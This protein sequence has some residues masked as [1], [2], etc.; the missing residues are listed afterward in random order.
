[1][2]FKKNK[3]RKGLSL[4]PQKKKQLRKI[5]KSKQKKYGIGKK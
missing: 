2:M 3:K 5:Y 4:S 1:M